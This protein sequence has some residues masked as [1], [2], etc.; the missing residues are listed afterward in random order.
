MKMIISKSHLMIKIVLAP[1]HCHLH[2]EE[3]NMRGDNLGQPGD[4][5]GRE[6]DDD[7][8]DCDDYGDHPGREDDADYDDCDDYNDKPSQ[9]NR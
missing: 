9:K 1:V 7:D 2:E 5:P 3:A 4:H 6:E 8:D